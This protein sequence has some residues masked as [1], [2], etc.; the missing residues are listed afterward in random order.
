MSTYANIRIGCRYFCVCNDGH[1]GNLVPWLA[2]LIEEAEESEYPEAT[3]K[4]LLLEDGVYLGKAALASYTY[5]VERNIISFQMDRE[6]FKIEVQNGK[7]YS[8]GEEISQEILFG[9]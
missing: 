7:M 1:P 4:G 3:L 2:S 8:N 9:V 6:Q 5:G